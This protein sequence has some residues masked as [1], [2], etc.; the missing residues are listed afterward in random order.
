M[1]EMTGDAREPKAPVLR[2]LV[3]G[4]AAGLVGTGAMMLLM[5]PGLAGNL[6]PDRRPVRFV[7]RQIVG[8][9]A[10]HGLVP[11]DLDESGRTTAAY[12]L[13]FL[14]GSSMGA[15]YAL[16]RSRVA[17]PAPARIGA[18]YGLG[19]WVVGYEGWMPLAGVRSATTSQPPRKW[20]VPILN[21]IL[22][23]VTTALAYERLRRAFSP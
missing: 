16:L 1:Y 14:Y 6:P 7:P 21:H 12:V 19:V 10:S 3:A 4:S 17:E 8:W 2:E 13:H 9:L 22:F 23:G 11:E 20:P 5:V 18:V 15:G